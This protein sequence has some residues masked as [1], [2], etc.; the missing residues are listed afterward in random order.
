MRFLE[1][2]RNLKQDFGNL[3]EVKLSVLGDSATQHFIQAL[4]GQGYE[5]GINLNIYEAQYN[6]IER[7]V[8]FND[9]DFY[10]FAAPFSL[11]LPTVQKLRKRFY[12]SSP[13]ERS[14]FYLKEIDFIRSIYK[15]ITDLNPSTNLIVANFMELNDAVFGQY[16]NSI[17]VSFLWQVRLLNCELMKLAASAP[18]LYVLDVANLTANFGHQQVIDHRNY[19][20]ADMAFGLDFVPWLAKAAVDIVVAANGAAKKCL[21]LDLD[22]TTW[23]GIIGDDGVENIQIGDLGQGKAFSE[24]QTW[25]R[26]LRL[27]GIL[28]AVC[29][30]NDETIAKG[31]FESHPDMV[32]SL[33]DIAIFVAN[34]DSKVDNI[35]EIK[36][37]LNIGYDAIV[38]VDDNPYERSVVKAHHPEVT[39]PDLP[40]DPSD[41]LPYLCSLNLFETVSYTNFDRDRTVHFQQEA[42]RDHAQSQF[43]DERDFL[44]SLDMVCEIEPVAPFNLPRVAQLLERSNQFNLRTQRYGEEVLR[45]F[46]EENGYVSFVIGARDRFGTYGIISVIIARVEGHD[47]FI[48]TWVMSCR[49]LKRGIEN[50]AVNLLVESARAKGLERIRGEYMQTAKN[51]LVAQHYAKLGFS[52]VDPGQWALPVEGFAPLEHFITVV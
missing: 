28:L 4:R 29:S 47:L 8:F 17:E 31:P 25:A 18:A 6:Q 22:N 12:R 13:E 2:I 10:H 48:D 23:G 52:A 46:T 37:F 27:R 9:S 11:I 42:K 15:Q 38:F 51:G 50:L 21:V 49:V 16:A 35:R 5:S 19:I 40:E 39:V 26:E 36:T 20:D 44:K 7:E 33:D 24:L 3:R 14:T 34:W 41:Y 43:T 1:L 45:S 32:L 30:K